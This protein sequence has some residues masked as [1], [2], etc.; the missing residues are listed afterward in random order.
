MIKPDGV[1]RGLV[2]KI[3]TRFEEKGYKL[4]AMKMASPSKQHLEAHY[5]DLSK[6]PFFPSLIEYMLSGPVVCMVWEGS[7]AVKIGRVLLGE[8][9][10]SDSTPGSIRGDYC[11]FFA[12]AECRL[13]R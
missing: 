3:I 7:H 11:A 10:P 12:R 13:D 2:G 4:V 1:Q 6:K 8:T 9:N 5:A